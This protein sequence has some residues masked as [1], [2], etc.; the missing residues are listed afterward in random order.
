MEQ[1]S[2][3][4]CRNFEPIAP[5]W[6]RIAHHVRL[7][8]GAFVDA[9]R[10]GRLQ[11][12]QDQLVKNGL[13]LVETRVSSTMDALRRRGTV[14]DLDAHRKACRHITHSMTTDPGLREELAVLE[15]LPLDRHTARLH[16][17]AL[18]RGISRELRALVSVLS[19]DTRAGE[20]SCASIPDSSIQ[21]RR[22]MCRHYRRDNSKRFSQ[23][24]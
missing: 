18:D 5:K 4:S 1:A 16:L 20:S 7:Y 6:R 19:G 23:S 12:F 8:H 3:R 15:F 2:T 9:F 24:P 10:L 13:S 14:L 11:K 21:Y 22:A 17:A